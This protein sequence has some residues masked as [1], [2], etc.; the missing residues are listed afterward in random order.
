MSE[1]DVDYFRAMVHAYGWT[2]RMKVSDALTR[3]VRE[4]EYEFNRVV[5]YSARKYGL[6]FDEAFHRFR[7]KESL[8][9]PL[10]NFPV[11]P[12]MEEKLNGLARK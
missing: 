2:I 9:E 11:D 1:R 12:E 5:G 3:L 8:G 10:A 6:T 7:N 4:H